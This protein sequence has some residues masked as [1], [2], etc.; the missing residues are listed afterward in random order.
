MQEQTEWI[1]SLELVDLS[2]IKVAPEVRAF[3]NSWADAHGIDQAELL[4]KIVTD[5]SRKH[6][7]VVIVANRTLEREGFPGLLGDKGR[8]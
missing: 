7:D 6:I 3:L 2:R 4:R 8:K 5:F 1:M